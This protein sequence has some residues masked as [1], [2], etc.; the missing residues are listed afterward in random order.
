MS[1]AYWQAKIWGLLHDPILKGL[2][3]NTGRGENSFWRRLGVMSEWTANDW[4]PEDS[5][6]KILK[7]IKLAD[8]ITSASDR[9]ALGSLTNSINY[10]ANGLEITH[11]LSAAKQTLIIPEHEELLKNRKAYLDEKENKLFEQIPEDLKSDISND[12][13]KTKELF[14]WLWRCLP[15]TTYQELGSVLSL[16]PAETRLPDAS[17][18]SH[19]SLTSAMAGALA[20]YDLTTEDIANNWPAKKLLSHP[21]IVSFTFS[22][23]QELIKASRKI[24]DFWA[25]SWILHYLSA[26]VSWKLAQQYGPDIFIYPSLYEQPLID[27]WLLQTYPD[28]Q[29]WIKQP[30]DKQLL[31]AGFPNVLVLVLPKDKVNGAMQLAKSKLL[32][33][34]NRISD[35]VFE[36]LKARDWMPKLTQDSS[37][38]EAWLKSQWQIYWT[39]IPVG[40]EGESL[41]SSEIYKEEENYIPEEENENSAKTWRDI[42]NETYGLSDHKALFSIH[43]QEFLKNAGKLRKERHRKHPFS[44]NVGSWWS[45]AFDQTRIALN[46]VK[47][48][49]TWEITTA[50]G[51]RSTVS[52]LGPV[53]HPQKNDWITEGETQNYWNRNVGLFDGVEQLNA[54]ETVKRGLHLILPKLLGLEKGKIKATYPDLTA[55]VAGY[56]KTHDGKA[57]DFFL[58]ACQ[59]IKNQIRQDGYSLEN[60]EPWGIPWADTHPELSRVYPRLLNA[61]WLVEDITGISEDKIRGYRSD[62][63]AFI[64]NCYTNNNPGNW[65]VLAAGDGDGM[66]NWLKGAN[67]KTYKEY[68]PSSLKADSQIEESFNKFLDLDKRMGPSTHNALSRALLDFSNQLVPYLTEERYAGRLI[69]SGGDDVLA[70]TN[71]WEW[72]KWLWD[73]RQCFKGAEDPRHEF[74]NTG[75]YWRGETF[76]RPLFTMG[77]L[78]SI[79]FGVVIAH[80]SVPLAIALE[81]LWDAE[82]EGAKKHK[83]PDGNEK[84]A[85]QVRV[86]YGNG[87]T[88]KATTKFDVFYQWQLLLNLDRTVESSIF[89]RAATLLEQHPIPCYEAIKPWTV[90]FCNRR[91]QLQDKDAEPFQTALQTFLQDLYLVTHEDEFKDTAKNWLKLAAFVKRNREIVI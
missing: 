19:L 8:Y 44:S 46:A 31:T 18:W 70:Y 63:Q 30:K 21:Y 69:Y 22:P 65:Y 60:S 55:G 28:F 9:S 35:L 83:S 5:G 41:T 40:K 84:D 36:E 50:F 38:W 59:K 85:V 76:N 33:E 7:H 74:D 91:E 57:L 45:H 4:N 56:L 53:V 26:S 37:T 10:N 12:L 16:M 79:S 29:T 34:W 54:T 61:G 25:G 39:G 49:R 62:L 80:H 75:D 89:E 67:L 27:H 81:N 3:S 82:K 20:G 24:R 90:V 11:L 71:L 64:D 72:D 2:H 48:A 15:Q 52:G 1:I 66:S 51:P 47:N 6:K 77:Q 13:S 42:Q 58:A 78:A 23:I 88:L 73:I 87:N 68:I 43:E 17:I 32:E 86:I 14:W